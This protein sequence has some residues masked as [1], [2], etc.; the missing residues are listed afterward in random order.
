MSLKSIPLCFGINQLSNIDH[1]FNKSKDTAL[2]E[3]WTCGSVDFLYLHDFA[4]GANAIFVIA[5]KV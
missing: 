4:M 3:R 1:L 5:N 2:F